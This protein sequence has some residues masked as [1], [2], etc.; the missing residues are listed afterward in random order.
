MPPERLCTT[1]RATEPRD[2]FAMLTLT[3]SRH[4]PASVDPGTNLMKLCAMWSSGPVQYPV[5]RR[6]LLRVK[7]LSSGALGYLWYLPSEK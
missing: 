4:F 5:E 6:A 1:T 2:L 3:R 7:L